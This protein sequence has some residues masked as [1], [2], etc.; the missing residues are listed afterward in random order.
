MPKVST[1]PKPSAVVLMLDMAFNSTEWAAN[2]TFYSV[3]PAGRWVVFPMRH[4]SKAG[5]VLAFVDGHSQFFKWQLVYNQQYTSG[6]DAY[7]SELHNPDIIWN[8]AYRSA[9]P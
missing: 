6:M 7:T 9:V 1:L 8:P 3:N 2:N 5:G 4:S